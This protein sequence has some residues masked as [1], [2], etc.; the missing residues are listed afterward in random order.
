MMALTERGETSKTLLM[1]VSNWDYAEGIRFPKAI[2]DHSA[3]PTDQG[4]FRS[5]K[6]SVANS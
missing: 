3:L 1:Q 4:W 5:A 2:G 6:S